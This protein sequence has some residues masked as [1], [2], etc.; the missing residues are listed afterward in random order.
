MR[1]F[2]LGLLFVFLPFVQTARAQDCTGPSGAKGDVM[3]N[4]SFDAFQGCT[5]RGWMAFHQPAP[6]PPPPPDPCTTSGAP[7][8]AC[9]DGQT[10]YA[11]SWNGSRYYTTV[12]DQ[13]ANAYWGTHNV[14]LG[15]N[16][17]SMTDGLT[18]TNTALA[19]IEANPG[20]SC[21]GTYNPPG[22][23]PNA[24]MLCK[25][26]RTTLGG[27]WY[28]PAQNELINVIYANRVAIGGITDDDP[29]GDPWSLE[30][31][32]WSSTESGE[33][34]AFYVKFQNGEDHFYL[35]SGNFRV[36]CVKR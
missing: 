13:G 12:A 32:Y 10:V 16:A 6:P 7:G 11:G 22:C 8:T 30:T 18:N 9:A 36:R 35:K 21:A 17:Q 20:A 25:D 5:S 3:F 34:V 26:L 1:L 19:S 15:A 23:A 33:E 4:S 14:L 27:D 2:Y 29:W 28:L 31:A 24:H